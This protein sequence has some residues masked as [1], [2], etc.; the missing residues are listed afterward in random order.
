MPVLE[1]VLSEQSGPFRK[2]T[3]GFLLVG[4]SEKSCFGLEK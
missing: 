2:I 3:T 4:N 1:P